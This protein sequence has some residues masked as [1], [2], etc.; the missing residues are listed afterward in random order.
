[1]LTELVELRFGINVSATTPT[2]L[3]SLPRSGSTYLQR[4]LGQHPDVATAPETWFLLPLFYSR[5]GVGVWAEYDHQTEAAAFRD[6]ASRL[7]G[8]DEDVDRAVRAFALDLYE[9]LGG[10]ARYFLDKTPRYHLIVHHLF[11]VFPDAKFIFLWRNPVSIAAS[12]IQAWG[13]GKWNLSYWDIDLY[14]G[15]S[16]LVH[17][18]TAHEHQICTL[19][20]EDLV[21]QPEATIAAVFDYLEVR[22]TA[23][24]RDPPDLGEVVGDPAARRGVIPDLNPL[25]RWRDTMA[26]PLRKRWSKAYLRWIGEDRLHRMGYELSEL[27]KAVEAIPSSSRNL[28]SDVWLSARGSMIS[29]LRSR[30]I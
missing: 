28:G 15:L 20:Y 9:K 5:R 27:M 11:R 4:L 7:P 17:A 24:I 30:L 14:R 3:L 21:R 19:R 8:G 25:D 1:M 22:P 26:N 29:Q 6:L 23:E 13:T 16:E 18:S 2:F 12:M 10:S